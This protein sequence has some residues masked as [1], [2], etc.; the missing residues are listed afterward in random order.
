MAKGKGDSSPYP[1]TKGQ[2]AS[3]ATDSIVSSLKR[4]KR[5]SMPVNHNQHMNIPFTKKG[6]T[7]E[8]PATDGIV[9]RR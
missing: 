9:K 4:G 6:G 2:I 3:P 1:A 7:I 5:N 8:T